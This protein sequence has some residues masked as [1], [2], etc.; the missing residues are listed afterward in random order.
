M[1]PFCLVIPGPL[2][3]ALLYCNHW[4]AGTNKYCVRPCSKARWPTGP[5]YMYAGLV[6]KF[7]TSASQIDW[8]KVLKMQQK[9]SAKFLI[10]RAHTKCVLGS[11]FS[12]MVPRPSPPPVIDLLQY[13]KTASDQNWRWGRPGNAANFLC[14]SIIVF[15]CLTCRSYVATI[16]LELCASMVSASFLGPFEK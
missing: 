12:S 2:L 3:A 6:T 4:K 1:L 11:V 14:L 10:P 5:Y 15:V 8:S 16:L 7:G 9:Y 13:A